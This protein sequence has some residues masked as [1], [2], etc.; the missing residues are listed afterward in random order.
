MPLL[1]RTE[2]Q[3]AASR[4]NAQRSTGPRTPEGKARTSQNACKHHLYAK[5]HAMPPEWQQR[6]IAQAV[7]A[8]AEFAADQRLRDLHARYLYL[9]LWSIE[10][11]ALADCY[12]HPHFHNST[13]FR[14]FHKRRMHIHRRVM[15]VAA[16][17]QRTPE[18][19]AEHPKAMVAAAGASTDQTRISHK[20]QANSGTVTKYPSTPLRLSNKPYLDDRPRNSR[21]GKAHR[22]EPHRGEGRRGEALAAAS[23]PVHDGKVP[24]S[25]TL[26]VNGAPRTATPPDGITLLAFLRDHLHLTGAKYGCGEGA[27]GACTVLVDG[28]PVQS[29]TLTAASLQGRKI[30]TIEG[31][32]PPGALHPV[33]Q[34]FL[35]AQAFQCGYCTP[36]M[37]L[38]SA[39]LLHESPNPSP[40]LIRQK[41]EGHLCRCGT[42][43]RIVEAVRLAAKLEASHA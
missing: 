1:R 29:C 35:D 30:T 36:A 37:I 39:A 13:L 3:L 8:T 41:L 43:P 38:A 22:A 4:A 31:L 11:D 19:L 6:I 21:R 15:H 2:K 28:R 9:E 32:A 40:A 26:Q 24:T 17:I 5:T 12:Y 7:E 34:A 20:T 42:Y 33:Q 25:I 18:R 10:L 27:C 23:H 16:E 14:V